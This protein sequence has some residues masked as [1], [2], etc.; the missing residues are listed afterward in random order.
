MRARVLCASQQ[1]TWRRTGV[2][3]SR[4]TAAWCCRIRIP[5]TASGAGSSM[6]I[7]PFRIIESSSAAARLAVAEDL[8]RSLPA[9]Q[10]VTIV[11]ASRGAAD[12]LARRFARERG[13]TFGVSRFS[14]T[15]LAARVAAPHLAGSGIAPSTA[16]GAEAVAA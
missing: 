5:G 10:P 8:L 13:A 16:L 12:D 2:L 15:Q 9:R 6:N 3:Q 1:L 7:P 11:A 14:L 4:R